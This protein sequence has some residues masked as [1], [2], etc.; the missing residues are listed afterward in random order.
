MT[1]KKTTKKQYFELIKIALTDH[2]DVPEDVFEFIDHQIKLIDDKAE[3][4]ASRAA[5]KKA[6]GDELRMAIQDTL[7]SEY[8]PIKD[9]VIKL[10]SEDVTTAKV[11]AR[12]TQLVKAGIAEKES[13]KTAEGKKTMGYKL[14]TETIE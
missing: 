6:A 7:T 3:R 1:E 10:E 12:L 2:S 8:Q 5:E 9:I 13:I 4:A 11:V 14:A